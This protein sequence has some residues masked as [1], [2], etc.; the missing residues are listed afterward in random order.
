LSALWRIVMVSILVM[1]PEIAGEQ[2]VGVCEERALGDATRMAWFG[3][4][5]LCFGRERL[6]T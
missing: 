2:N 6:H 3:F 1:A 4:Y 5:R